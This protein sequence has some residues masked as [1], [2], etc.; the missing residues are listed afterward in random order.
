MMLD[1]VVIAMVAVLAVLGWSIVQVRR[2]R[3]AV[4]KRTQVIL[5]AALLLAV[6]AFELEMRLFG[7]EDRAAGQIGGHASATV[8]NVLYLH[9]VFAISSFFLWPS[10][11][12]LALRR[13]PN[14]PAPGDHSRTHRRLARAA[15][16]C[17]TFTAVTG[18]T[19]YYVAFVM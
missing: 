19:F 15:A 7:W 5:T 9:L 16:I 12:V 13:F 18:W 11:V 17:M 4:H 6:G 1:L 2:G 14:P 3:F 10:V 8:W